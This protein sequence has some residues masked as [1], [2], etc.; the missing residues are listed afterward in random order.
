MSPNKN[1]LFLLCRT[2]YTHLIF[3]IRTQNFD[4]HLKCQYFKCSMSRKINKNKMNIS[5]PAPIFPA[6]IAHQ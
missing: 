5:E 6:V 4:I 3:Y 1:G 2:I